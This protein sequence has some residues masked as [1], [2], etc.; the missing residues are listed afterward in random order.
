MKYLQKY[1]TQTIYDNDSL[2]LP[3]MSLIKATNKIFYKNDSNIVPVEYIQSTGTQYIDTK[4]TQN[5]LNYDLTLKFQWTGDNNTV[6]TQEV[7]AGFMKSPRFPRNF[8]QKYNGEWMAGTNSTSNDFGNGVDSN[9]H[10]VT[11]SC[12]NTTETITLD[13]TDVK[14]YTVTDDGLENNAL[15]FFLFARNYDGNA[16]HFSKIRIM[17][18]MFKEYSDNTHAS[19]IKNCDFIPV[20]I[21]NIGYMFDCVSKKLFINAGTGNFTLGQDIQVVEYLE[22]TSTTRI[23]TGISGNLRAVGY[24][25]S[26]QIKGGS[27]CLICGNTSGGWFGEAISTRK[28]GVTSGS[29]GCVDI[30]PTTPVTFDINFG[31]QVTGTIN[32]LN[33]SNNNGTA[34]NEWAIFGST[35]GG[36]PFVGKLYWLKF[37]QNDILVRDFIPVKVNNVGYMYDKVS[38]ELFGKVGSGSFTY[39]QADSNKKIF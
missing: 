1:D 3:N 16:Q 17:R 30:A 37:Y 39:G 26:N 9:I 31:S 25:V 14:T 36:Y 2:S 10:T 34:R 5:S 32:E 29:N 24:A 18:F 33:I 8:I 22:N 19:V 7:F 28:W 23:H 15:S 12:T 27:Q 13:G 21:G 20:R 35:G 6:S 38:R 4:I 11:L